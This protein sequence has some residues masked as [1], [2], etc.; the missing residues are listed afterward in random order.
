M[1][2]DLITDGTTTVTFGTIDKI[3]ETVDVKNVKIN[4]YPYDGKQQV[5]DVGQR[6]KLY[7]IDFTLLNISGG[8][9]AYTQYIT[10]KDTVWKTKQKYN[11]YLRKLTF[12]K[13]GTV[14]YNSLTPMTRTIYG[15]I[16]D[17]TPVWTTDQQFEIQGNIIFWESTYSYFRE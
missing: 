16:Q 7:S 8:D 6:G 12:T 13:P 2:N 10:L 9:S 15:Y 4:P 14:I 11:D 1:G 3:Q 5:L 17:V